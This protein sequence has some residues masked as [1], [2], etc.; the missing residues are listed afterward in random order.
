MTYREE[1]KQTLIKHGFRFSKSMGQNFLVDP[2][3]PRAIA[4]KARA[5]GA[6]VLEIGPGVGIL[7]RELAR[8]AGK[9]T[10]VEL[11]K[12]LLPILSETLHGFDNVTVV[13]GDIM[14]LSLQQLVSENMPGMARYVVCA[15]LPYNITTPVLT[16]LY[17]AR[18]FDTIT[19]MVQ[20]EVAQRM[21]A[22]AGTEEYG[23]FSVLTAYYADVKILFDVPP[24]SF[25]PP[26]KVTSSVVR[27]AMRP[28][29]PEGIQD[30]ALFF[31]VV[32]AA[33]GQRRKTLVNALSAAFGSL[34]KER[35]REAVVSCGFDERIRGEMLGLNDFAALAAAIGAMAT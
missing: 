18:L 16:R 30:E 32:R 26:P 1:L 22:K 34:G 12:R 11:D 3:V 13:Q 7:T 25:M 21:A 35:L 5:E 4:E 8:R 10:T 20:R 15:N 23:A 2:S 19:V 29:P 27:L 33:F 24:E 17:E 14:R 31:R 6:G 9:V 28:A